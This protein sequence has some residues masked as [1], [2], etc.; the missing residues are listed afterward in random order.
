MYRCAECGVAVVVVPGHDPIRAC[1][2]EDAAIIGEMS[3]LL[4]GSGEVRG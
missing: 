1:D 3:A 2:H 4:E